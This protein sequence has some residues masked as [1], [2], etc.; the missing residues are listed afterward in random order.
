MEGHEGVVYHKQETCYTFMERY[1]QSITCLQ[2]V[3]E[4]K[5]TNDSDFTTGYILVDISTV[6]Y[7]INR[8]DEAHDYKKRAYNYP[9]EHYDSDLNTYVHNLDIFENEK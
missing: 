6:Y 8:C 2:Q 9:E 7:H 3:L 5:D 4:I 1:E